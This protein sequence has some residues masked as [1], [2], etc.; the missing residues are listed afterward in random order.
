MEGAPK[1]TESN[2]YIEKAVLQK[3]QNRLVLY[4]TDDA[5]LT[6][7]ESAELVDSYS[8]LFPGLYVV[9]RKAGNGG[10]MATGRRPLRKRRARRP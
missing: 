7:S 10:T 8:K 4:C 2:L 9:L 6:D 1:L 3:T 5:R